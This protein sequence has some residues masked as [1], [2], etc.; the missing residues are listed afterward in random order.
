MEFTTFLGQ[1]VKAGD[2]IAY[3]GRSGSSLWMNFSKVLKIYEV[4]AFYSRS[5]KQTVAQVL[6]L[7]ATGWHRDEPAKKPSVISRLDRVIKI[8]LNLV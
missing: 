2:Y 6:R 1:T 3:P 8:D 4:D 5:K 7:K